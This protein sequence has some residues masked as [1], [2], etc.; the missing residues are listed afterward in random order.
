MA[1]RWFI[2]SVAVIF[3]VLPVCAQIKAFDHTLFDRVLLQYVDARGNV[4]YSGLQKNQGLLNSYL[5]KLSK[6]PPSPG[7][8]NSDQLAYW[9]NVYNAFTL[10]LV[11]QHYPVQSIKDIRPGIPFIN[12]VWDIRFIHIGNATYDLNNIEHKILRKQFDEPRIHFAINCASFSC[13]RLMNEAYTGEKL[14]TQLTTA[15][16]GFLADT[17]KNKIAGN[18]ISLSKIFD[19]FGGDFKKKGSLIDFLNQYSPVTIQAGAKISY[20]NYDWNLNK[21]H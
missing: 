8:S 6:N 7:W 14:E 2:Y 10:S 16:R 17:T 5:E 3:N 1:Y 21:Q 19:W 12:S 15:A 13:P 18:Q 11:A 9:I 20:L 4:D